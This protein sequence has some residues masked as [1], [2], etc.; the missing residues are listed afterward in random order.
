MRKTKGIALISTLMFSVIVVMMV[1]AG[2]A[3]LPSQK[4]MTSTMDLNQQALTAAETGIEY[5]RTK[6]QNDPGWRGN[7]NAVTVDEPG[8][9]W[10]REEEGNIVGILWNQEGEPSLFK[11]RFNFHDGDNADDDDD[12]DKDW[13][14][15]DF[16]DDPSNEMIVRHKFISFNSLNSGNSG[17]VNRAEET[18]IFE[19][20]HGT[21]YGTVPRFSA[22]LFCQ[23]YA[24]RGVENVGPGQLEPDPL[25]GKIATKTVEAYI[26]RDVSQ[27][28]DSVVYGAEGINMASN[29]EVVIETANAE[30]IPRTRSLG[31]MTVNNGGAADDFAMEN[32]EVIVGPVSGD[33]L[34]NGTT[35]SDPAPTR[36]DSSGSFL[37]IG[38]DQIQK[39]PGG[40]GD[41]TVRAGTYVWEDGPELVYYDVELNPADPTT[42]PRDPL[43]AGPAGVPITDEDQLGP[44]IDK[45]IV[46]FKKSK[47]E[48]RVKQSFNVGTSPN[49]AVGLNILATDSVMAA[50][51]DRPKIEFKPK[52]KD[53]PEPII[54][55]MGDFRMTGKIHGGGAVTAE[56]DIQ[57][58]GE[59]ILRSGPDTQ[60][61][62]YSKG[63][64]TIDPIPAIVQAAIPPLSNGSGSGGASVVNTLFPDGVNPFGAAEQGD[65]A[66]SGVIYA[67]GSFRANAGTDKNFHLRGVLVAY[68]GSPE[69]GESPGTR[70]GSGAVDVNAENIQFIYDSS[71]VSNIVEQGGAT[72]LSNISWRW[73]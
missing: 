42:D 58:Q 38:W 15:K 52:K 60:V 57:V 47:M 19:I 27:Y 26:G 55:T 56:G 1:S 70:A 72:T 62:L 51:L 48:F 25:L 4:V 28:G 17:P 53:D 6:L 45:D 2:L 13:V 59:S 39:A 32:G 21:S 31:S 11:M 33:F 36:A 73:F 50:E 67:Q 65:V 49:G 23:G 61:A 12:D 63:D 14:A 3:L 43:Y 41:P 5:A 10:I 35:S 46:D 22:V 66:F 29:N 44:N 18:G 69:S 16:L 37:E 71:F 7:D 54:T 30:Y 8:S 68:G 20:E 40:A 24:G 64:I 34:L 9:L